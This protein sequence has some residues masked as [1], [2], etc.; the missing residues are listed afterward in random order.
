MK[1]NKLN[2]ISKATD[3]VI[4]KPSLE[5]GQAFS[6]I[7]YL[8]FG[9]LHRKADKKRMLNEAYNKY[10]HEL[11]D[12]IENIPQ[13]NFKDSDL[14]IV[15]NALIDSK[16]CVEKETIRKMF[17]NLISASMNDKLDEFVHPSFSTILRQMDIL[18][19]HNLM[20]FQYNHTLPIVHYQISYNNHSENLIKNVF[21]E[22]PECKNIYK[23][24]KS[25]SCLEN[26][27]LVKV[28]EDT[29][30]FGKNDDNYKKYYETEY[31]LDKC[32]ELSIENHDARCS[33]YETYVELTPIGDNLLKVCLEQ[34]SEK[35]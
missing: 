9:N 14:Q 4:E 15:A 1:I 11:L 12:N 5:I 25:I 16:F 33:V 10:Y 8:V 6:D 27:G 24:S 18:D 35:K 20:L 2:T 23:Q 31:Y 32:R 3:I 28:Y 30:F 17:V 21:L 22:N 34:D 13:E 29:Y 26:L 7:F 19:A